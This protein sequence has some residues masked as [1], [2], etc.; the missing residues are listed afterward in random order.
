MNQASSLLNQLAHRPFALPQG[1]WVYY[2]EWNQALFLHWQ[3]DEE[4][5]RPLVPDSLEIDTLNGKAYVSLVAFRMEHIRPRQLP[6]VGFISNFPEIN[7][8]TYVKKE[9][10]TGVYFLNIEAGKSLSVFTARFLSGLPYEKSVMKTVAAG[11]KSA[12][13][14]K[15]FYLDVQFEPG[16]PLT[17]KT[18]AEKWLTER[19][20][21]FLAEKNR[22][23]RFDIHHPE[24]PLQKV[25]LSKLSLH[26]QFDNLLITRLPD[27]VQ[28]SPG[29]KVL[30][31]KKQKIG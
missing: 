1:N 13:K 22:L 5:L 15:N 2:Q 23:S 30:A 27:S 4:V 24:W 3:V 19:Y 7:I 16:A 17:Q 31:W 21:L 6:A 11:F 9:D 10:K 18:E 14:K 26:Y 20:C 25:N 8:R 28:Y 29:V 12:H